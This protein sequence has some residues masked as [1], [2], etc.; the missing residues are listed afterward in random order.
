[1]KQQEVMRER[2]TVFETVTLSEGYFSGSMRVN[3]G[4]PFGTSHL[5]LWLCGVD[6]CGLRFTNLFL[7]F[8]STPCKSPSVP[9]HARY[10]FE[11]HA[12]SE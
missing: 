8:I 6:R 12:N 5:L 2:S 4:A 10:S 9:T 1:M 11:H 7:P 3:C